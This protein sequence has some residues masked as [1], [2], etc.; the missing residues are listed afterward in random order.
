MMKPCKQQGLT[1]IELIISIVILGIGSVA[2]LLAFQT[3]IA[4]SADPMVNRQAIAI[5]EAYLEEISLQS[6]ADPDGNTAATCTSTALGPEGGEARAVFDDVDDYDS[7]T[8]VGAR[9]SLGNAIAGLEGY[10][11]QIRVNCENLAGLGADNAKRI[12][13]TVLH[14]VIGSISLSTVRTRYDGS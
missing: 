11:V 9:D 7:L 5:A 6:F 3:W 4:A 1:L 2:L 10:T 12:T 8:D 14:P 13:A